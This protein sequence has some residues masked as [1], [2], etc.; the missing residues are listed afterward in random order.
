[1][2]SSAATSP[3]LKALNPRAWTIGSAA[4]SI[5]AGVPCAEGGGCEV[6]DIGG[7]RRSR[8]AGPATDFL[9]RHSLP[10]SKRKDTSGDRR[11]QC[12]ELAIRGSWPTG[13][14]R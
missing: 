2:L 6:V 1:M 10:V 13:S 8:S 9:V 4:S 7:L 12:L 11:G 3:Q 14:H 5:R